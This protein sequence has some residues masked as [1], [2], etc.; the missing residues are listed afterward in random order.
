MMRVRS[1]LPLVV[2]HKNLR[3]AQS[4]LLSPGRES[5]L[6]F[7]KKMSC[8][9]IFAVTVTGRHETVCAILIL[10]IGQRRLV[11]RF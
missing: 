7:R 2:T 11:G 4:T 1:Q 6:H 3:T 9:V 5:Q 10:L 8:L